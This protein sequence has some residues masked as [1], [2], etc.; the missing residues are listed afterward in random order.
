MTTF[1]GKMIK[2]DLKLWT[3]KISQIHAIKTSSAISWNGIQDLWGLYRVVCWSGPGASFSLLSSF[4]DS[5]GPMVWILPC[6][7]SIIEASEVGS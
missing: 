1:G 2:F 3:F 5:R 6:R 4:R 7:R